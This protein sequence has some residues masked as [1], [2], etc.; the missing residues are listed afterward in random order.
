MSTIKIKVLDV[1]IV[2]PNAS[3][4]YKQM[5][6][7]HTDL[8]TGKTDGK[9]M[10]DIYT[11][12]KVYSELSTAKPG[13]MYTVTRQKNDKGYWEWT[14]LEP[15]L[16]APVTSPATEGA[17]RSTAKTERVGSWET[18]NERAMRQVYIVRQSSIAN[19]VEFLKGTAADTDEILLVAKKFEN[20]VFGDGIAGLV[21]DDLPE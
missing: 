8:A 18:P 4:T 13:S 10:I 2:Q 9:K 14:A 12:K 3:K 15:L 5:T 7:T 21:S 6:C 11:D 20:Y 16:E 1:V 17:P 19:A